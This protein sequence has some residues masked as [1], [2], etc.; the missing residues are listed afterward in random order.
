M[1]KARRCGSLRTILFL[2]TILSWRWEYD[3]ANKEC[4]PQ[5]N[6]IYG[7]RGDGGGAPGQTLKENKD[8]HTQIWISL[9][10]KTPPDVKFAA[11]CFNQLSNLVLNCNSQTDYY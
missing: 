2:T 5:V 3:R 9:H 7:W 8:E 4:D 6:G 10:S 11:I 1:R